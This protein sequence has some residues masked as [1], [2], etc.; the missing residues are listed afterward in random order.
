MKDY[1]GIKLKLFELCK[2]YVEQKIEV[3][4]EAIDSAQ[5]SANEET[6][7]SAGD[8]YE[9]G[10]SMMQLEIEKY[11]TQLTD[12][13]NLKKI[14]SQI[15]FRKNYSTVQPGS[16]V[17]TNNG[18]FLIAI[19]AGKLSVDGIEYMAVSFSSPIGQV[20]SNKKEK[21]KFEF[22]NKLYLIKSVS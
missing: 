12:G 6:R 13:L 19:S 7:S 18:N 4:Q 1:L 22:R 17:V 16:L 3:A 9:T 14:L 20:L 10:R 15:D 8:K 5:A 21:D 2:V 11:S